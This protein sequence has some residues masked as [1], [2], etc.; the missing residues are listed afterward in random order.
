MAVSMDV[1]YNINTVPSHHTPGQ[2]S[3]QAISVAVENTTGMKQ[4]IGLHMA[5]KLCW[6]G[7]R[8]KNE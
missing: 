4:I 8:L 3:S 7:A 5:N 2:N 6:T 1:R